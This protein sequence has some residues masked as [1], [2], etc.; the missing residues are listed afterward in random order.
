MV[1]LSGRRYPDRNAGYTVKFSD[2]DQQQYVHAN[3]RLAPGR[4]L[5]QIDGPLSRALSVGDRVMVLASVDQCRRNTAA[6]GGW[7]WLASE[8]AKCGQ[9]FGAVTSMF[10]YAIDYVCTRT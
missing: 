2:G 3:L 6:A 1:K 9:V 7:T 8:A 4:P 5:S 10:F